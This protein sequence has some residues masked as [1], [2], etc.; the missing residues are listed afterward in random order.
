MKHDLATARKAW[1]EDSPSDEVRAERQASDFLCY[2]NQEGLF[3]D[4]HANRHT[5]ISNLGKMGV[6]LATAQKLARHSDP[7]LTSN[8]YTHIDIA[9]KSAAI[10]ALPQ[11]PNSHEREV[12]QDLVH[13]GLY[14][15]DVI[16]SDSKSSVVTE[17]DAAACGCTEANLLPDGDLAAEN[18][19]EK[20]V[21]LQGLEPWT[22]G[23]KVR[24]STN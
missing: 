24:C 5:F 21:R 1:I 23:L 22:Y 13:P 9:E 11:V 8:L 15:L 4:F 2:Q 18:S 6:P 12:G 17:N 7:R 20:E 3:A 10:D 19:E 14:N 16:G